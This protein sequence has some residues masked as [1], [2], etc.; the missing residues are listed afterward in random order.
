MKYIKSISNILLEIND[1]MITLQI[2]ES[3]FIIIKRKFESQNIEQF[4]ITKEDLEDLTL[5]LFQNNHAI[6]YLCDILIFIF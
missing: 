2:F 1:V 4:Y 3:L 5:I 6:S